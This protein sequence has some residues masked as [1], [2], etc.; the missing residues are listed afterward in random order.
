[1]NLIEIV[2]PELKYEFPTMDKSYYIDKKIVDKEEFDK[3]FDRM[4]K[5]YNWSKSEAK[6]YYKHL[7]DRNHVY[8]NDLF[9]KIRSQF[10]SLNLGIEMTSG[11][12]GSGGDGYPEVEP[13]T[14]GYAKGYPYLIRTPLD[15]NVD[16][17]V[18]SIKD[19]LYDHFIDGNSKRIREL[20]EM[21]KDRKLFDKKT[22]LKF[23][24][25][26]NESYKDAGISELNKHNNYL[27][28]LHWGQ[29]KLILTEIQ[30]LTEVMTKLGSD[31]SGKVNDGKVNVIYPGAAPG[32]HFL[33]LL[34][35]FPNIVLYLWDPATFDDNL[36]Y[37]DKHRRLGDMNKIP[38]RY[39]DTVNKYKGRVFINPELDGDDWDEY[40]EN[41]MNRE[42]EKNYPKQL[43]FFTQN[44]I[45]WIN[46][47]IVDTN[48]VFITD[49]RLFEDMK[50]VAYSNIKYKFSLNPLYHILK[51]IPNRKDYDRDMELQQN[52]FIGVNAKFG[53]FK[54]KLQKLLLLGEDVYKKYLKGKILF[55][56]WG[57][58]L[59]T[60][61]RLFVDRDSNVDNRDAY[62]NII[63][64]NKKL[65]YFNQVVRPTSIKNEKLCDHGINVLEDGNNTLTLDHVWR[66]ILDSDRIGIDA[67]IETKILYNF[68]NWRM[69]GGSISLFAIINL[70]S[71]IT[72]ALKFKKYTD[73]HLQTNVK[74][75]MEGVAKR[76]HF[77]KS[78][79]G[80]L[81]F[82]SPRIDKKII[83]DFR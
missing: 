30:F 16:V 36:I 71:D 15:S 7:D 66:I 24:N 73:F 65:A 72:K 32:T 58:V 5:K 20:I 21:D 12:G 22:E 52:W 35:M 38:F 56:P 33:L 43:G 74:R 57:P 60:E 37:I 49:I 10:D 29:R 23:L 59:T 26:P 19:A 46:T 68:L 25:Y 31:S 18:D 83:C 80:R 3:I 9:Q 82:I 67:M 45:E 75:S 11:S 48:K 81:D 79:Q 62:Y 50:I 47:K 64:Y 54:F 41:T 17:S 8:C 34:D 55:Q 63:Q 70:I 4:V 28:P 42:K 51:N 78:F 53:L 40:L 14:F 27:K 2:N 39:R 6:I 77:G 1:M 13:L 61:T 44:S 76:N 69:S